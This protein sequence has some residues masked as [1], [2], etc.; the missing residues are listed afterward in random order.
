M[1]IWFFLWLW[2][3]FL[4]NG[5]NNFNNEEINYYYFISDLVI[6]LDIIFFWVV[7]MIMVGYEYKGDMLFKNV[8]FIGIVCDKLGCKMLKFLGNLFDLLE[9]IDKYG[10]DGVWMG[11]MFVVFVGNDIL[12]DDVLCE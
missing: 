12:F 8:Y 9:L 3:I 5:I 4:F 7:W 1:D 2:F 10:V 11:M 6:G